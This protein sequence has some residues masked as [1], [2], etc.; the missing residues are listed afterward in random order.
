MVTTGWPAW[1]G[2]SGGIDECAPRT[3][4]AGRAERQPGSRDRASRQPSAE[5]LVVHENTQMIAIIEFALE[6]QGFRIRIARSAAT[7]MAMIDTYHPDLVVLD[8]ATVTIDALA[9]R[10]EIRQ[11]HLVPMIVLTDAR[12]DLGERPPGSGSG[13]D[14]TVHLLKPFHPSDLAARAA[15][16]GRHDEPRR[17]DVLH[18]GRVRID[19]VRLIV[20]V[21]DQ[22]VDLPFTLFK[23]LTHLATQR[24]RP[25]TWQALLRA[26]WGAQTM[27]GGCDI[28]KSAI[29]RLRAR[30]ADVAGA[31][32]YIITLRGAGYLMPDRPPGVD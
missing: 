21:G 4:G 24:G 18:V 26:V 31:G 13:A 19:Q 27:T 6:T 9:L 22:Q 11:A 30:L 2:P 20:T 28:V 10:E 16:L 8:T 29:Y 17:D 1:C 3:S 15:A 7:A 5:A 14:A 25:Q 23:L 32:D 12:D